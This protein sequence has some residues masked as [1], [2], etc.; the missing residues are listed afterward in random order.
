M[1]ALLSVKIVKD[2]QASVLHRQHRDRNR[3]KR[4]QALKAEVFLNNATACAKKSLNRQAVTKLDTCSTAITQRNLHTQ[5]L[6]RFIAPFLPLISLRRS[7]ALDREVAHDPGAQIVKKTSSEFS[8]RRVLY[9]YSSLGH[10][11]CFVN[12]S[13]NKTR[14]LFRR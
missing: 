4:R 10:K 13:S 6:S 14:V 9:R 5:T 2:G 1:L 8:G 7:S 12:T 3:I 11:G